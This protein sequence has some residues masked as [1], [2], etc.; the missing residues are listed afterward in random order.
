MVILAAGDFPRPGGVARR[1]LETAAHVVCCDGAADA[2]RRRLGR[3]PDA[4]VGD[5]DS[6]KGRFPCV[7][8]VADQDTNDLEK[9][10]RYCRSRGWRSPVVV[11]AVGKREDHTV[12][13]VFR[14]LD[15]DVEIVT[16]FGRFTPFCGRKSFRTSK[17]QA[18]SVFAPDPATRMTSKGLEWPLDGVR[19][20]NLHCA[21]LNRATGARVTIESDRPAL[22]FVGGEMV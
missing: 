1:L 18:V 8:R 22:V 4:V 17:G 12:G 14:A 15:L 20:A 19:F 21:T 6:L 2:F 10:V 7:V 11:G 9:A 16:D 5:C 3:V 13:N